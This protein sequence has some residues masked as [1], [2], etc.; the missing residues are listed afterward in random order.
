MVPSQIHFCCAMTVASFFFFFFFFSMAEPM[1]YA[2]FWARGRIGAAIATYTPT[3]VTQDPLT[4]CTGPGIEPEPL[5]QLEL[6]QLCFV[7]FFF[8]FPSF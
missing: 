4:H 5:Q 2:R 3:V 7:F 8:F 1:A 6:L